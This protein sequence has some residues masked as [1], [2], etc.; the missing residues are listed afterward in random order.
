MPATVRKWHNIYVR[1]ICSVWEL[2]RQASRTFLDFLY[3]HMEFR[4]GMSVMLEPCTS[5]QNLILKVES[6]FMLV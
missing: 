2:G 4:W 5:P 3:L 6:K 1:R